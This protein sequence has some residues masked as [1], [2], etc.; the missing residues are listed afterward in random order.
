MEG[1]NKYHSE[2]RDTYSV[3][4]KSNWYK[5][6]KEQ[7]V[8]YS[9]RGC[10]IKNIKCPKGSLVFW[11]SRTIHCGIEPGKRRSSQNLRAV[12]YLCYM[13]RNICS[14]ANLKKKQKAFTELRATCHYPCNIK[15]FSKNPHT[16][17][18]PIPITIPIEEPI[19]DDLGK[20]LSGF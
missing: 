2:F 13:P 11:D 9:E 12:I 17:G 6:S 15:L 20:L 7:R 3:T 10:E 18:K 16:Y 4:D 14:K 19:V 8:F 5:L 1:S